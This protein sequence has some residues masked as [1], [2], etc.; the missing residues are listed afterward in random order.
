ML[1]ITPNRL[2]LL[3]IFLLPLPCLLLFGG[4][5]SK[6]T[7]VGLGSLLGLTDY[8]DGRLARRLGPSRLGTLLDPV[9]DKIFVG[10]VYLL[11]YHLGY[12][13]YVAVFFLLLREIL[14]AGLRSLCP[15]ELPVWG[16]SRLK[17]AFQMLGA[18]IIVLA[19]NFLPSPQA[20]LVVRGMIWVVLG[21]T[22]FS[23][24]PYLQRGFEA[25]LARPGRLLRLGL[26][27]ALPL[28]CLVFFP[29]SGKLWPLV[30]T[31]LSLGFLADFFLSYRR[32]LADGPDS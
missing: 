32:G 17:T 19:V 30:L 29:F 7:A 6:L 9:A 22:W 12:L 20:L 28:A 16:L 24:W 27:T 25:L 26:R 2:T 4:P 15:G 3:R 14:V 1:R 18:G 5:E 31:G 13:P 8:L 10:V 11:L 21:L 23:A